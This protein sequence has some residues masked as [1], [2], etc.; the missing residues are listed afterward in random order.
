MKVCSKIIVLN[1]N[2][3]MVVES[4]KIKS[5]SYYFWNDM[6]YLD[7][8]DVELVKAARRESRIDV[9]IYYIGYIIDK[10]FIFNY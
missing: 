6:V 9:D 3:K 4:L 8:F 1:I 5:T 2:I 7:D 10:P